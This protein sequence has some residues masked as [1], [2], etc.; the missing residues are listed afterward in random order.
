MMLATQGYL[1]P[2]IDRTYE[3]NELESGY[4]RLLSRQATYSVILNLGA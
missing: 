2:V 4:Q 1:R 3:M